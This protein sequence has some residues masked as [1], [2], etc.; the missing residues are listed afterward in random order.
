MGTRYDD[1]VTRTGTKSWTRQMI[2]KHGN[3]R[4]V[5]NPRP[6]DDTRSER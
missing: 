3:S 2:E 1:R 4:T 6:S 5:P